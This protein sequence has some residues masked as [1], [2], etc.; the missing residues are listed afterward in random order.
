MDYIKCQSWEI[1]SISKLSSA[2]KLLKWQSVD[3]FL[4]KFYVNY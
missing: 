1:F 3:L 4:A 2:G